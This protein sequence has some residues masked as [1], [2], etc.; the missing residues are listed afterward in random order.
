MDKE[1]LD[2]LKRYKRK[3]TDEEG[4]KEAVERLL[5]ENGREAFSRE[6]KEILR[7][8]DGF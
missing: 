1:L 8:Q 3:Y 4:K 7:H 2:E 6:R 5:R